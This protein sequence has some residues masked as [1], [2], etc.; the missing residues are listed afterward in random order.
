M[1]MEGGLP[2]ARGFISPAKTHMKRWSYAWYCLLIPLAAPAAVRFEENRG[3]TS[4]AVRY[5]VRTQ[6]QTVYFSGRG[7]YFEMWG[8][9]QRSSVVRMSFAGADRAAR[10]QAEEPGPGE[11]MCGGIVRFD[12]ILVPALILQQ[13]GQ[14]AIDPFGLGLVPFAIGDR[15]CGHDERD[16][17]EG[18]SQV[19]LPRPR[20]MG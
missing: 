17:Q 7:V 16:T 5:L 1:L 4:G 19:V 15:S 2:P 18:A 12:G 8:P 20:A 10:W 13:F 6:G 3:Q 14:V 11:T 9:D